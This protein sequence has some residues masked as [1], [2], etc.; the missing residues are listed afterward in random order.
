MLD[1]NSLVDIG[2]Y[3]L[4][5]TW[6]NNKASLDVVFKRLD[7]AAGNQQW[8]NPYKEAR[9][10]NLPLVHS[11]HGPVLLIIDSWNRTGN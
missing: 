10:K 5:F 3:D 2:C 1:E 6:Y 7:G 9:V 8:I 11:D 4:P